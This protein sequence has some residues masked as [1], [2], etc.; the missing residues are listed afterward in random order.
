MVVGVFAIC[1]IM[2]L[3]IFLLSIGGQVSREYLWE[4]QYVI[5]T[6]PKPLNQ[7]S[8]NSELMSL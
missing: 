3:Y 5:A 4:S 7:L 6:A 8:S 1:N 2:S